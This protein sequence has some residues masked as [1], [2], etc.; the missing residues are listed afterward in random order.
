MALHHFREHEFEAAATEPGQKG[1]ELML[2]RDLSQPDISSKT[3]YCAEYLYRCAHKSSGTN[4]VRL[5]S[6]LCTPQNLGVFVEDEV[7]ESALEDITDGIEIPHRT[8]R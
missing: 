2:Q 3:M 1:F 5:L 6:L 4:V 7:S 8:E